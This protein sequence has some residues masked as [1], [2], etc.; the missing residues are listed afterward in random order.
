MGSPVA[1]SRWIGNVVG[2]SVRIASSGHVAFEA[3]PPA[4]AT[5]SSVSNTHRDRSPPLKS[6]V[7]E[8]AASTMNHIRNTK[9]FQMYTQLVKSV[10][11]NSAPLLNLDNV[12]SGRMPRI[13]RT[14]PRPFT[15]PLIKSKHTN[16]THTMVP[17]MMF[18]PS[19]KYAFWPN[20]NP[21][22]MIFKN[23]SN[24]NRNVKKMSNPSRTFLCLFGA[25][26]SY[27]NAINKQFTMML[28]KMKLFHRGCSLIN[29][30]ALR[31]GPSRWNTNNERGSSSRFL[32][33]CERRTGA[34]GGNRRVRS[35]VFAIRAVPE[36]KK[37]KTRVGFQSLVRV[38]SRYAW[39]APRRG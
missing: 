23:I 18:Q 24:M 31:M 1:A 12:R 3:S 6:T 21:L 4:A 26:G 20:S 11:T 29:T 32:E 33:A 19:F 10:L 7:P 15:P 38:V 37:K 34:G 9:T 5:R 2:S 36:K 8:H 22:A 35:V 16:D 39:F 27:K 25:S 14:P 17:S 30:H 28:I 13:A